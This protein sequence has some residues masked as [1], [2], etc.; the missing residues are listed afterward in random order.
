MLQFALAMKDRLRSMFMLIC[1]LFPA[2]NHKVVFSSFSGKS[3]SDSPKAI[4]EALHQIRPDADIVWL[5]RDGASKA[6]IIPDYV[7]TARNH[8]W[9]AL[10]EMSTAR[11]WVDNM[12]MSDY[13]RKR[14][15]QLY[16]QTWHGDRGFKKCLYDAPDHPKGVEMI[17]QWI[18]DVMVTGSRHCEQMYKTAFGFQGEPL[19]VGSP[20]N[21]ILIHPSAAKIIEVKRKLGIPQDVKLLLYAPTMRNAP[22]R[23]GEKQQIQPIDLLRTMD[24]LGSRLSGEFYCLVRCHSTQLGLGGL[25]NDDRIIDAS[26]YEDMADLLLISDVLITDYSSSAGD[27]VLTGRPLILFHNDKE[28]FEREERTFYFDISDT[29]F[30]SV[31][32]QQTLEDHIAQL[33]P[34]SAE[35]ND[36]DILDFYGAYETGEAAMR[37]AERIAQ[38]MDERRK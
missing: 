10:R 24:A 26:T 6:N 30:V 16:V 11:A 37:V 9:H 19:R 38:A 32:D 7:R 25:P 3:Y 34:E 15:H 36:R 17:E 23:K 18:A 33:T 22:R 21:D 31:R 27:F 13:T 29:P 2:Q 14:N 35:K 1:R 8:S 12:P 20:R 5:F 4:S 28:Q